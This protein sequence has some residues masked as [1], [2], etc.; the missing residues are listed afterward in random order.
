[1]RHYSPAPSPPRGRHEALLKGVE[2]IS[3]PKDFHIL[4]EV[5][6][7]LSVFQH[8][9]IPLKQASTHSVGKSKGLLHP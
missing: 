2:G 7:A 8:S 6:Q 4:K 9:L 3:S 5:W 1:M